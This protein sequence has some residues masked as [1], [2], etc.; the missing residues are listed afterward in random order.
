MLGDSFV[1]GAVVGAFV[2]GIFGLWRLH[3]VQ[4]FWVRQWWRCHHALSGVRG[5]VR[6]EDISAEE[7]CRLVEAEATRA[8]REEREDRGE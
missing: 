2:T 8:L 6:D 5:T 1:V 7:R 3:R 4:E